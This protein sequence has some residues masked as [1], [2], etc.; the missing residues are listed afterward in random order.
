MLNG[1]AQNHRMAIPVLPCGVFCDAWEGFIYSF[2]NIQK[3]IV[4]SGA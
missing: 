3:E 1:P 2:F 4:N